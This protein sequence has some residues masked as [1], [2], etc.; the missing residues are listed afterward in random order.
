MKEQQ[1]SPGFWEQDRIEQQQWQYSDFLSELETV[2]RRQTQ[3]RL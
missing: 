2:D 1:D 3:V